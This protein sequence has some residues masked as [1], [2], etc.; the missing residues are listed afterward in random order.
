MKL[1]KLSTDDLR[2]YEARVRILRCN[3][4]RLDLTDP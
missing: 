1:R 2:L 4:W 3:D